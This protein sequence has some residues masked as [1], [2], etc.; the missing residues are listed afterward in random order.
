MH[1]NK[2]PRFKLLKSKNLV[3]TVLLISFSFLFQSVKACDEA[4]VTIVSVVDL[5]G[6]QTQYTFDICLE[7]L[8]LEGIPDWFSVDFNPNSVNVVSFTPP[9]VTTSSGDVFTGAILSGN[10]EVRWT[11]PGT[12]PA[13]NMNLMCFQ[14]VIVITGTPTS[15]VMNFHDTYPGCSQNIPLPPPPS[16]CDC[17]S[18]NSCGGMH[19]DC[20]SDAQADFPGGGGTTTF[21]P[22]LPATSGTS[23]QFCYEY[24]TGPTETSIGFVNLVGTTGNGCITKTYQVY[25]AGSCSGPLTP[26]GPS[27]FGSNGNEYTVTANTTYN[28]CV[29]VDVTNNNCT[30]I[31]DNSVWLYNNSA[32]GSGCGTCSAPCTDPGMGDVPTYADRT[33][34]SC[35]SPDCDIIGPA[36]FTNCFEATADATGFLGFANLINGPS[37]S[38]LSRTWA[39]SSGCGSPIPNPVPNAHSVSSGFNPEYTGLTPGAT[40]VLCITYTL[41]PGSACVFE[42]ID[43]ICIDSYGNSCVPPIANVSASP[44]AICVGLSTQLTATGGGTYQWSNGLGTGAGPK[45]VSPTTT[46]TYTVTVTSSPGCTAT[47]EVTVTVNSLTASATPT[48]PS[49]GQNNG[50]ISVSPGPAGH[51]YAWSGGLAGQ[52][53]MNVGPGTYTV[54]VT[55]TATGCTDIEVVVINTSSP[56]VVTAT[57]VQ[58]TCGQNNGSINVTPGPGGHTYAWTGGLSGQNPMNV[59]SGTYTVTVTETATGCTGTDVVTINTSSPLNVIATPVQPTCGQNNGSISVTPGPAGHTYSWTGGLSGQNPM[60]VGPGTYTVTVT[61]TATGC[62]GTDVVTINTSTQL[63]VSATPTQ[64]TCGQNNGSISVTPGPGGHTYTWTGGLAGQNPMNVGPGTYT[65]TVTET[66]TGCTGT[67][68]IVLNSSSGMTSNAQTTDATCGQSNGSYTVSWTGGTGPFNITGSFIQNNANSPH[69]FNNINSGTYIVTI[70]DANGCTSSAS[71]SVGNGTGPVANASSTPATCGSNNGSVTVTWAN[72]VGPFTIS[73]DLTQSNATTPS[74]FNNL[75]PGNYNVIVTDANG[76]TSVATAS[77]TISGGPIASTTKTDATCGNSNGSI[78]VNWSNGTG[79]FNITGDLNRVNVGSPEL[80]S[81]LPTGLYNFI[82]TDANGCSVPLSVNIGNIP[83]P[84]TSVTSINATCGINNGEITLTWTGGTGPFT[85]TGDLNAANASSPRIFTNL[86]AGLYSMILTDVNGCTSSESV[87]ITGTSSISASAAKTD[88]TCGQSNGS[89]TVSWTGGTGPYNISGGFSQNNA[90]SPHTFSNVSSGTYV[91]TITDVNGCTSSASESVGNGSGPV[92]NATSTAATCGGNNGSVTVIWSNG[93]A[94]FTISGDLTQS[95]ASSP[96][97]F[98]NLVAGAYNVIVSDANGCTSVAA[99][100]VVNSGGPTASATKV[101]AKCGNS[102]GSI[103]V[104]WT[105]GTGPFNIAGDL[106]RA[107]AGSPELFSNLGTGIYNFTLT[108][109]SGCSVPLSINIGNISGP[110]TSVISTN[111]TCGNNNG[112]IT[113]SWSGGIGPFTITGDL[114]ASNASSP[115][116]FNNLAPGTY[117]M[118][119]TDA[120]GCTSAQTVTIIGSSA[121]SASATKTDAACGQSNGSFTVSWAGGTGPYNISGGFSQNNATSP[122]T[123]NNVSSGTYIVTITDANGCTST[124]SASIGNGTGP[125]ANASSIA[126]TCGANNGNVTV[127][128]TNGVAPFSITGDLALSNATSPSV[129]NNLASG[130]YSIVVTDANG[131]TS[132]ASA[133]VANSG[134]PTGST[135]KTDATC[136]N[137]NGSITISWSGGTGPYNISGDLN[138]ANAVS[139]S[140]FNNLLAKPYAIIVTDSKGCTANFNVT[141]TSQQAL[142]ITCNAVNVSQA[143]GADGRIEITMSQGKAPY[144]V[145]WQGTQNGQMQNVAQNSYS[146]TNLSAGQYNITVTDANGCTDVCQSSINAPG[147]NM[148]ADAQGEITKCFGSNDGKINLIITGAIGATVIKW[149]NS[150]W[151]GLTTITNASPGTYNVTITDSANCIVT[152][153]VIIGQ[154]TALDISCSGLGIS[155]KGKK[156]GSAIINIIGGT[157]NYQISWSGPQS[158]ITNNNSSGNNN[159]TGLAAGNY[160]VTVTDNNGC[161]QVCN[162]IIED[163][164]CAMTITTKVDSVGCFGNCDGSINLSINGAVNPVQVVWSNS[165][166]NGLTQISD[167]C[168]GNYSVTVTDQN[169][170]TANLSAIKVAEPNM[171]EADI[172][173]NISNPFIN[174]EIQLSLKTNIKKEDIESISWDNSILLSCNDCFDPKTKLQDNTTFN[175]IVTDRNGCTGVASL[176][177]NVKRQNIIDFPNIISSNGKGNGYFYPIGDDANIEIIEDLRVF[178]RW[179]NLVFQ[180][181]NFKA[182]QP[183]EGWNGEYLSSPVVQGVYVYI[184][185]VVFKDG[186]KEVIYGDI[187]VIK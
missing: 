125:V 81:N 163:K 46:T 172:T 19:Y 84:N 45:N 30:D 102:N 61:E 117:N 25:P 72:G 157:A 2:N 56:I 28:F 131:C 93:V 3:L 78:T 177:I 42:T 105:G 128:W 167:L 79:P 20:S 164:P 136:G 166:W 52:N 11:F 85:I 66:A 39:L 34:S 152:D 115:R 7:M 182:N 17:T 94:P 76:C 6:G 151:N 132:V 113:L 173:T 37:S 80:F 119:V 16:P 149:S 73:G 67:A 1:S 165:Q 178:D 91:V 110:T 181:N 49:C 143:N 170:C 55:E 175:V 53:P 171:I 183:E 47:D 179:G 69:T 169:G 153:N 41:G 118:L 99:V 160:T 65:V 51:T 38:C 9:T 54:T 142:E 43:E 116:I 21:T 77:I 145:S 148:T 121:V 114:N 96:S 10:D 5:G 12:F 101:D 140:V 156:D 109:A 50:S 71:A 35:W 112:Q 129:F 59:G 138:R 4:S 15:I 141:I 89:F 64:P 139:P 95:N 187:T 176:T 123:F 126:A 29:T 120:N 88:A 98:N 87:T 24:T 90:T 127:T 75:V 92:A 162:F 154:P 60:N 14:A 44:Q 63:T 31:I 122:Q 133:I 146:I 13:H 144:S 48:Q 97:V 184:V 32:G 68:Q 86:S 40:Y 159:I 62:T 22:P 83:G 134:G 107:N 23:Y 18:G 36:T 27:N 8:G 147:C 26:S 155:Q 108:D 58:P 158:G 124:A 100:N 82:L 130:S 161:T 186:S 168:A 70:T 137:N 106:V 33:Y 150:A 135:T 57:P 180:N 111:A 103:N 74:V 174:Q 185:N 104:T